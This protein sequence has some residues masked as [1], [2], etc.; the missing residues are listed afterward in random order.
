MKDPIIIN[1]ESMKNISGGIAEEGEVTQKLCPVCKKPVVF[2]RTTRYQGGTMT[3]YKCP[4]CNR[5]FSLTQ[6][7]GQENLAVN[8]TGLGNDN[9]G[10]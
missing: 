8:Y 4:V 9:F 7:N 2:S 1:D 6:I 3:L 5:E 10:K